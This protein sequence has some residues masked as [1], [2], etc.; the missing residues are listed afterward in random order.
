MFGTITTTI[1]DTTPVITP[2][3]TQID[4]SLLPT[5]TLIIAP[6]IPPSPDYTPTS[7]DY[8]PASDSESDPSSDH[9]PPLPAI[10]P[11]L[12][13]D[14]DTT[15]SDTPD[16]PTSPTHGTPF[17]EITAS[18]QRSP[19]IP[20]RRVM[21]L[22]PGQP[23]PHGRPYRY[24]LNGPVHMMTARKRVGPLPT[25]RLAVRHSADHSS[26]NS[27]SE[28]S[29]DFHSDAS[30]DPSSRHS[31][32]NHSSPDLSGTSAG[33]SRKRHRSPMT[34]VPA[35]SPDLIP[36][37]KRVKDSGYLADVEVDP[38]EIS[39]R[40]DAI[41][42]VNALRD[43]GIDA[44]VVVEAIDRDG[45]ETGMRGPVKVRVERVTHPV[46]PEDILEPAQEGAIEATIV[47][48]ESAVI[49]LTERIAELERD[50]RRL[51]DTGSV[52]SQR[53]D[54]LLRGMSRMQRKLRQM[55]RLRFYDRVRVGRLEACARK[56]MGYRP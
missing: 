32:L 25:H 4:T 12:S 39:L 3:A 30:S 28:A 18:T 38:R 26:S 2:P 20:R 16:T 23:I 36:S 13:S 51:R 37:P 43:R 52:K 40:D 41:A 10:S 11:F 19:I 9:I 24:H 54:R 56:H 45:T 6:T 42:R 27:S 53:V 21:I 33:P 31:L 15:D 29:S 5:E 47:G 55:R 48:V 17:T 49:A 50:N 22:S 1:P 44:R 7:L 8:S 34:S 35:L 14:D 46:M